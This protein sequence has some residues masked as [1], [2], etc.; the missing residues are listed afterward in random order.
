MVTVL[1]PSRQ[2]RWTTMKRIYVML[3][4]IAAVFLAAGAGFKW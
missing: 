1:E 2:R 3:G 4:A